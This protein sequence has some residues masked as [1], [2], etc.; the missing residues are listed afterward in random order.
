MAT[1]YRRVS[2]RPAAVLMIVRV[3]SPVLKILGHSRVEQYM[4]AD[5][6]DAPTIDRIA[7]ANSN[8]VRV[9]YT[10]IKIFFHCWVGYG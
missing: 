10:S 7:I 1:R 3:S 2:R 6:D 4:H 8:L 9:V 5:E